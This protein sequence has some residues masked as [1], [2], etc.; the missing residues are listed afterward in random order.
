MADHV[1]GNGQLPTPRV[2]IC[3]IS[4]LVEARLAVSYG[5]SAL[6]LVA[7]MPSGP[8]VIADATIAAIARTIPPGV[9]S[10]LL[11]SRQDSDDIILHQRECRTNTVQ[12]VDRL[13]RG[14]HEHL[15]HA[16]HGVGLVQV[17]HVMGEES[18]EEALRVAP[19]V[20]AILLD[21]GNQSLTVKELGGTGRTHD[22]RISRRIR[23]ELEAIG[24]PMYLAGGLHA[25]NVRAA[26][27]AVEPFG[28]DV[29]SGV[30]TDGRLDERKLAAFFEALA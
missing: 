14:S 25:H 10:F 24:K 4:S 18:V 3:C 21:S 17:V 23:E 15:R 7:S 20:D 26:I 5:A 28:V 9:A 16:L 8:G 29:C 11:T 30:R 6:G 22:W 19:L 2:K 13:E 27:E 1:H 12:I